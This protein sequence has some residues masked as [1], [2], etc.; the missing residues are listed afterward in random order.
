MPPS[1]TK[2][3]FQQ[4]AIMAGKSTKK[5]TVTMYYDKDARMS[6]L[7]GKTV[8]ILGYGSQGHAHAQNLR[9]SGVKVIVA[10]VPGT[11]N[12]K[13][14]KSHKFTP[15]T[16][17]EATRKGDLIIFTLPDEVAPTVYA[18][19]I[20]PNLRPG[21][22]L[23]FTHGFNI[24]YKT[25]VPPKD[26]DVIMVAPKGPGHLV[27]RE[28]VSGNGVPCL[29]AVQ[30]DA[31]GKALALAL[32]WARGMG[33]TRAGCIRTTFKDETETDLFGEQAI[34]CGGV[35]R[36][37][38]ACFE[39]LTEAG[40]PPELAYFECCHE[41]KLITDLLY[42]GGVNYM[43][44]SVSNTA[45]YGDLTR[46]KRVI[47]SHVRATLKKILKEIT[48]GQFAREWRRE[49]ET[50]MK[51]FNRLYKAEYNHPLEVVGRKLRRMMTW[52]DAK[53]V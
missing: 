27:R 12:F 22:A 51:N 2:G 39:T 45:E 43:R 3:L 8:A 32:A 9:D 41:L 53:E 26:V 19:E 4:G 34:L 38:Q 1:V 37:I 49:Y 47:D 42:Q 5:S 14:A 24:H 7:K 18:R 21:Q 16:A 33:G 15:M 48:S 17:A 30:Q 20:A 52:I 36:L 10:E 23:G 50:G 11:A 13:L 44:Y 28:F 6:A 31:T 46:G 25:I 29:V 35:V 40:Y